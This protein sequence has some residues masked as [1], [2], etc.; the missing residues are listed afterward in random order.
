MDKKLIVSVVLWVSLIV[1]LNEI[2]IDQIT[3]LFV[4][5]YI[6]SIWIVGVFEIGSLR[7]VSHYFIRNELSKCLCE[8][9][10]PFLTSTFFH[11]SIVLPVNISTIKIVFYHKVS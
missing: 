1:E 3:D 11:R 9:N 5:S 2:E 10:D 4:N 7:A 6:S 8:F